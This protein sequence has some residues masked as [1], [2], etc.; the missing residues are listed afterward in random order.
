LI[1]AYEK[2][3]AMPEDIYFQISTEPL[4]IAVRQIIG[5]DLLL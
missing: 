4:R 2:P 5:M 1:G 3:P